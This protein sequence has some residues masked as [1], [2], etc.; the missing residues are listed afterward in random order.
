V[1]K[2]IDVA[3]QHPLFHIRAPR[4]MQIAF[5]L[6]FDLK[7]RRSRVTL[8]QQLKNQR[9]AEKES[10]SSAMSI[11]KLNTLH[12]LFLDQSGLH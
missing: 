7:W 6:L 9:K 5:R 2:C 8:L 11:G 3:E 10:F 1:N 4:E 12:Y